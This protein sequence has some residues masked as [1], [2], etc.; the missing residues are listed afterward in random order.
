MQMCGTCIDQ[1]TKRKCFNCHV[2]ICLNCQKLSQLSSILYPLCSLH[3][4][5][6]NYMR[7]L[8]Y[9]WNAFDNLVETIIIRNNLAWNKIRIEC[10]ELI[11][12][13]INDVNKKTKNFTFVLLKRHLIKDISDIVI[14]Y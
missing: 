3:C 2:P 14:K 11:F 4:L 12:K 13:S 6:D 9:S 5:N 8:N 1:L 10:Q 7:T